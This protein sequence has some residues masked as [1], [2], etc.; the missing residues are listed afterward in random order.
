MICFTFFSSKNSVIFTGYSLLYFVES[1]SYPFA[2]YPNEKIPLEANTS[3]W[4]AP[5][6]T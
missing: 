3:V 6:Q 4:L 1:P 2:L 5:Q